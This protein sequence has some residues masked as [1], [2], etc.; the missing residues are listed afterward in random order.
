MKKRYKK[1]VEIE[2]DESMLFIGL[3]CLGLSILGLA[4][5]GIVTLIIQHYDWVVA[6]VLTPV[7]ILLSVGGVV[8]LL[9]SYLFREKTEYYEEMDE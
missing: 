8:L 1:T 2:Y 7:V 9:A 6:S 3:L 4:I 5:F